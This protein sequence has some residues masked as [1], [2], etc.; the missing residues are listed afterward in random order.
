MSLSIIIPVLNEILIVEQCVHRLSDLQARGA[1]IVVVD[2]GSS[3]GTEATARKLADK[4][5]V[6]PRGRAS[7][8]NLG[9]GSA[10]G[11]ILLFLH[12]DTELPP[13]ADAL[14]TTA[15]SPSERVWGR[16][17][18]R[19]APSSILLTVVA[20][21]MNLR[22]RLSGIATGDQA[23]FVRRSAFLEIG[24]YPD[25]PLMEDIALSKALKRAS[26]PVCLR[27][28]VTTSARRWLAHGVIR[29]ILSMWYLRLAY[30][31]G[32]DPTKLARMYGYGP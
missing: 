21:M 6:G 15:I 14:I 28:K 5:L 9:A 32:A 20:R 4:F 8:M 16:F 29:T 24:G 7:Q 2:G 23:I 1:E 17:D 25:I 3:D 19:I 27:Q 31:L 13:H 18:V 22:S 12:A 26:R 11:E 30:F 10:S